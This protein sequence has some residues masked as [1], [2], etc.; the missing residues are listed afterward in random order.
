[1]WPVFAIASVTSLSQ[2][3]QCP[4][5]EPSSTQFGSFVTVQFSTLWPAFLTAFLF[6]NSKYI[7]SIKEE[8]I[9]L[10]K[11]E[12]INNILN[13]YIDKINNIRHKILSIL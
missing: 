7:S 3:E 6:D 2:T 11:N 4:V 9:R 10:L 1:M 12:I 5:L 13:N 8:D